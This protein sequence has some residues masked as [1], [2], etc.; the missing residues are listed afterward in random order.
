MAIHSRPRRALDSRLKTV[1]EMGGTNKVTECV[2]D[3][4][5]ICYRFSRGSPQGMPTL[6][7]HTEPSL[8]RP[9]K[10]AYGPLVH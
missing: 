10:V 2:S 5:Y 4:Y 3:L 6:L 8:P 7:P 9:A 1:D